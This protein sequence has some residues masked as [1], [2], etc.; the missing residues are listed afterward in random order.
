MS[1][2][3]SRG[4]Y[5]ATVVL[6]QKVRKDHESDYRRWQDRLTE[7]ARGFDGFDGTEVYPPE[8]GANG[9]WVVIFRFRR[10]D[11]LTAWLD[12]PERRQML[13]EGR[14]LFE[15]PPA[16]DVLAGEPPL[17]EA[18]TAV[19]SH[20]VLT[21]REPQFVRWHA[22]LQKV[23]EKAPG[24]MGHELFRP[25]PGVQENWVS[26]VRFDTQEH[27]ENWLT[28]TA[29]RKLLDDGR[30]AF[31][32]YDVRQIRSAFSGWFRFG[33]ESGT[34]TVP[35]NWKQ[36]MCVL[37]GLYPTVMLLNLTVGKALQAAQTPGY[38]ALF[39]SNVLS[40]SILTWAVMPLISRAMEFWLAPG[41]AAPGRT[42]A[43]GALAVVLGYAALLALFGSTVG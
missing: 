23:Q 38:L 41:P 32:S 4:E 25:V 36:A 40:V 5:G 16:Q 3:A 27:L 29:R 31:A 9:E 37:L 18:V 28:S 8:D 26:I 1:A 22:K 24:Y 39:I 20:H 43:L 42:H 34:S 2:A 6:S 7:L 14:P 11:Q 21:S 17:P 15:G 33:R 13:E 19:I 10:T 35:P 30:D 12:S